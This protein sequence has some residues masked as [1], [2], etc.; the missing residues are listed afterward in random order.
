[1]SVSMRAAIGSTILIATLAGPLMAQA[2][3]VL[4]VS[5]RHSTAQGF[6]DAASGCDDAFAL[7]ALVAA[8]FV[9]VLQ[10]PAAPTGG[11]PRADAAIWPAP[12]RIA[13][14]VLTLDALATGAELASAVHRRRP[15]VLRL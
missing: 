15:A 3:N 7:F 5:T 12:V 11:S 4:G 2:R 10:A 9:D 14:A 13:Q 6:S 8:G 1:M